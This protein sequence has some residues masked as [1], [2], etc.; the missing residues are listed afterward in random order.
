MK[1]GRMGTSSCRQAPTSGTWK[2]VVDDLSD[3]AKKAAP[4]VDTTLKTVLPMLPDGSLKAPAYYGAT[5]GVRFLLDVKKYGLEEAAKREGVRLTRDVVA[6][7]IS[8]ALWS[9]VAEKAPGLANSPMG[10][11]A[12]RAFKTT[13][14]DIITRGVEAGV[15][16]L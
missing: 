11:Y 3:G 8:G 12:E 7:R 9:K 1:R 13:M 2:H 4:I 16:R 10:A 14:N 6:P 5:E 15:D